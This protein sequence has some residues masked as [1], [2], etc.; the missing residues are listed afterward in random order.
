MSLELLTYP[1]TI[2]HLPNSNCKQCVNYNTSQ[3]TLIDFLNLLYDFNESKVL[4]YSQSF[5]NKDITLGLSLLNSVEFNNCLVV[6]SVFNKFYSI[7][8]FKVFLLSYLTMSSVLTM[9]NSLTLTGISTDHIYYGNQ[10]LI[11]YRFSSCY[12]NKLYSFLLLPLK[13]CIIILYSF[14]NYFE[15][16][17]PIAD[18]FDLRTRLLK[19]LDVTSIHKIYIM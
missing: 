7:Q 9:E 5:I 10:S 4:F 13:D 16:E 14:I 8:E 2:M 6:P 18:I 12:L 15:P 3:G 1:Q 17:I 11:Y 19:F